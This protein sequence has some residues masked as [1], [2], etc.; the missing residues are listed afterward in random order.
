[1]NKHDIINKIYAEQDYGQAYCQAMVNAV[2]DTISEALMRGESVTISGFGIFEMKE[3]ARKE[4]L[5]PK[6]GERI[7]IE[8]HKVPTFK[9]S[10]TFID[11]V[12]G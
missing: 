12:N 10:K 7:V 2:F 5:H 11:K 6:T 3:R 9:A 4:G 8:S 1:M